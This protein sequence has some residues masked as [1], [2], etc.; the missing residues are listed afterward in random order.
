M[1]GEADAPAADEEAI[2]SVIVTYQE[3][4]RLGS[5]PLYREAFH[6]SA[7][8]AFPSSQDEALVHQAIE[9]FADEV[10]G[11]VEGGAVVEERARAMTVDVAG[12]VAA[13]RVDFT[14]RLGD[15]RFE[16]TDFMSLAR[17]AGR[18]VITHK[19]YDMHPIEG[20]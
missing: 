5:R 15:E 11:M 6:P 1:T 2:R 8:V 16:G 7:A 17:V 20:G 3:A 13:V 18:W 4:G 19:L 12:D 9:E 14:L 10:A